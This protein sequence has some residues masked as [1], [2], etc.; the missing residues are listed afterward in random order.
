MGKSNR[1]A[2]HS[3]SFPPSANGCWKA[4]NPLLTRAGLCVCVSVC[5]H[6]CMCACVCTCVGRALEQFTA[7]GLLMNEGIRIADVEHEARK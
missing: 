4:C 7:A 3:R 5:E 1:F 2:V 6:E